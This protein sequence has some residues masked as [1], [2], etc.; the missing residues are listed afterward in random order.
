M[1]YLVLLALTLAAPATAQ[2]APPNATTF[3]SIDGGTL[4]LD[5]W[6]GQPVLVVNTASLCAYAPQLTALQTLYDTYKDEGLMVLAVPSDDFNQELATGAE[7]K[8]YCE[9]QYGIDLPMT[10][11]TPVTGAEAH[12][13]YRRVR[14]E[15]GFEPGWNFNKILL[16]GQGAVVGT[17]GSPADPMGRQ[18]TDAVTPLLD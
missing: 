1:R 5:D 12:P 4:S 6:A 16:D 11:I 9:L 7:V 14:A 2:T 10:D 17:W 13:F 8:D 3:A 15:T 18:I